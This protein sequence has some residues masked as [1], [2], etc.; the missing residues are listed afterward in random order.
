MPLLLP[1]VLSPED[2]LL[3]EFQLFFYIPSVKVRDQGAE[4]APGSAGGSQQKEGADKGSGV[5]EEWGLGDL[6]GH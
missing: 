5:E 4:P 1:T 3:L 6:S 2:G